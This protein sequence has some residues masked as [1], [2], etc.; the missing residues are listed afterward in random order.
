VSVPVRTPG[1]EP[2]SEAIVPPPLTPGGG[3]S[4]KGEKF[5]QGGLA[6]REH[7]S[8]T[9]LIL[10]VY[11]LEFRR[12]EVAVVKEEEELH[13]VLAELERRGFQCMIPVQYTDEWLRALE[14]L[15]DKSRLAEVA[16]RCLGK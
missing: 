5:Y 12:V 6:M 13:R 3:V 9:P 15:R 7:L 8:L 11:T 1:A 10:L 4:R 14:K 16:L 2:P